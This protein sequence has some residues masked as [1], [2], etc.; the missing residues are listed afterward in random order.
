VVRPD[1]AVA[2]V[3]KYELSPLILNA[4]EI[5]KVAAPFSNKLIATKAAARV[6]VRL[7]KTM[8]VD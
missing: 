7:V 2:R 4:R 5:P 8:I 6:T 3:I 1:I